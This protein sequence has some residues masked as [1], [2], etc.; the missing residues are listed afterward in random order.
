MWAL[1]G[2]DLSTPSLALKQ[3]SRRIPC[4]RRS[5][6][7]LDSLAHCY[8]LEREL[9]RGGMATVYLVHDL[10]HAR[11][12]ALK[13]MHP[14]SPPASDPSVSFGKSTSPP[15][16]TTPHHACVRFRDAAG[17]LGYVMPYV[18]GES[19]R[20]RLRR[21]GRLSVRDAV[22][23]ARGIADALALR[24]YPRRDSTATS[25]P[26]DILL[27]RAK[28]RRQEA[29]PARPDFGVAKAVV[30]PWRRAAYRIGFAVGTPGYVSPSRP[31]VNRLDGPSD[32][33]RRLRSLRD[34]QPAPPRIPARRSR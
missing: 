1:L 16:W 12:L 17:H 4:L 27:E 13:I 3:D 15:G 26:R 34:A 24:P 8:R 29:C 11:P 2:N 20:E 5:R 18:E 7:L 28:V 31:A 19:L 23:I 6:A 9:G 33:Y 25:S 21:E 14:S 32:L 30:G 10:K 22:R